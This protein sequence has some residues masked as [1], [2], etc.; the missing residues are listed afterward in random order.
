MIKM[1]AGILY[2]KRRKV[3]MP[4]V[5]VCVFPISPATLREPTCEGWVA[6]PGSGKFG[7]YPPFPKPKN[8][9]HLALLRSGQEV[10]PSQLNPATRNPLEALDSLTPGKAS[11]KGYTEVSRSSKPESEL[12]G[13]LSVMELLPL[14]WCFSKG[15][16]R[17]RPAAAIFGRRPSPE[18]KTKR[19]RG[20]RR[21]RLRRRNIWLPRPG[22]ALADGPQFLPWTSG[23]Q[24]V[25]L[26][27]T[28]SPL[29]VPS[30]LTRNL[31]GWQGPAR[32]SSF[33]RDQFPVRFHV[34]WLRLKKPEFQHGL[35]W[36][37]EWT[38]TCGLPPSSFLSHPIC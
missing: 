33:S 26:L 19:T 32:P 9:A 13:W 28:L 30:Q 21:R 23:V 24:G 17:R 16:K 14:F 12:R 27:C 31:T 38:K 37:V 6:L 4:C 5:C 8:T 1:G 2:K 35:P 22:E 10:S 29:Q 25:H 36:E 11:W 20:R 7:L 3:P 15:N 18:P 34:N